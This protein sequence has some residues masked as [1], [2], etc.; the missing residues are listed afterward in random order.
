MSSDKNELQF[1]VHVIKK[2][3][4]NNFMQ[5]FWSG[6]LRHCSCSDLYRNFWVMKGA[7]SGC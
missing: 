5:V 7:L 1:D 3:L 2:K 6:W 4:S